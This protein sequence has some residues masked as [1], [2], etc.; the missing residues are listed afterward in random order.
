[1]T[2]ILPSTF[3]GGGGVSYISHFFIFEMISDMHW[4]R[5]DVRVMISHARKQLPIKNAQLTT[6]WCETSRPSGPASQFLR[7]G[8]ICCHYHNIL[9]QRA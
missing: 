5:D 7:C 8:H 4:R 2:Q 6:S 1:M 9:Y 3:L